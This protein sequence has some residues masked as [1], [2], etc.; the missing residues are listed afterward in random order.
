MIDNNQLFLGNNMD[1]NDR[2]QSSML[3]L[4]QNNIFF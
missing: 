2:W 4:N 3:V 1:K